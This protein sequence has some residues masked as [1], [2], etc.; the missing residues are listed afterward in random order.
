MIRHFFNILNIY[1]GERKTY[2]VFENKYVIASQH[3][4][5]TKSLDGKLTRESDDA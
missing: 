1:G 4:N 2:K 5:T 3:T